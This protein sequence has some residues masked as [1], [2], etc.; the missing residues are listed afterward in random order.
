MAHLSLVSYNLYGF[1][2]GL[3]MLR[4]LT[5]HFDVIC[6]QEHWLSTPQFDRLDSLSS[7]FVTSNKSAMDHICAA[8]V[9]HGRP[10]GG[11]SIMVHRRFASCVKHLTRETNFIIVKICDVILVNVDLPCYSNT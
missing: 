6:V 11:T 1:N 8:D 9:L 5:N 7:D 2:Q 10:F 4:E 3:A